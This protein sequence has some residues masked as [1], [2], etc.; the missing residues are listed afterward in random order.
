MTARF[1]PEWLGAL[2]AL[3]EAVW[4]VDEESLSILAANLAA[5]KLT[6]IAAQDMAGLSMQRLAATPQDQA[7]WSDGGVLARAGVHSHTHV[8]RRDG[9]L[10]PVEQRVQRVAS[11]A[12]ASVLMVTMLD[13]S[14]Q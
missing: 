10:V 14:E 1:G 9:V 13:R 4:L 5:A 6:G 7:L 12:G 2:D 11:P 3:F 8:L